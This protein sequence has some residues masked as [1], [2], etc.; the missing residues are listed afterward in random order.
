MTVR[1]WCPSLF[2]PMQ[3]G[4]GW[5]LR[6]KPFGARISADQAE[7]LADLAPGAIELTNRG[8]LQ[9]RGLTAEA[10]PG[11]AEALLAADLAWADPGAE[12]RRNLIVP[13]LLGDDRAH[14][15][16]WSK[17]TGLAR[18]YSCRPLSMIWGYFVLTSS[19]PTWPSRTVTL[20]AVMNR[21]KSPGP[22]QRPATA[23]KP[24]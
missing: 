15:G 1:G 16:Y 12:T 18:R 2:E 22:N 17:S 24:R 8:N 9:L 6:V 7:T 21:P 19:I 23:V 10:L 3:S 13:P 11:L 20:S 14:A 4:D 5:L